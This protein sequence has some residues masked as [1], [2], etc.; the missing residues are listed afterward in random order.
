M[1]IDT[2]YTPSQ[3]PG[4]PGLLLLITTH[5]PVYRWVAAVPMPTAAVRVARA[6]AA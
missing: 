6:R 5:G 3:F 4:V 2:L 1:I